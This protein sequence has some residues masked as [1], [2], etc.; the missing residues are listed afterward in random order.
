MPIEWFD[1]S[2]PLP[3]VSIAP[4]GLTLNKSA[5]EFL[6]N[7]KRVRLGI[8]ASQK[9]LYIKA[10][11]NSENGTHALPENLKGRKTVR[12]SCKDF[13]KY[14]AIK[15]NLTIANSEKY[16]ATWDEEE[17]YIIVDINNKIKHK[18]KEQMKYPGVKQMKV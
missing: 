2:R 4:Y 16:M 18:K 5:A 10:D 17:K 9:K 13:I 11:A 7:A 3:S 1:A 8:D 12:I 6:T 15:M 14:L